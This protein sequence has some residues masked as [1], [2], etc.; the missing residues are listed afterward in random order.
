LH[1][2]FDTLDRNNDGIQNDKLTE[3][4]KERE[5]NRQKDRQTLNKSESDGRAAYLLELEQAGNL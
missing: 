4:K 2:I 5:T 3:S 1:E